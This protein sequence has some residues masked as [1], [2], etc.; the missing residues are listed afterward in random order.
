MHVRGLLAFVT[1]LCASAAIVVGCNLETDT[2]YGNPSGLSH[3]NLPSP[4]V[5]EGG[6]GSD[7]GALCNGAGPIDGGTCQVKFS[8]DIW[9]MMSATGKWGCADGACHGGTALNPFINDPS[10]AYANLTA[11]KIGG[12]PYVNPCTLDV[13]ASSF[14]CNL[15]GSCG[16]QAMPI[17][18]GTR[19][20][21]Q[22]GDIGKVV[23][24][25]QC[26]APFN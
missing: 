7:G 9:P 22:P 10:S 3:T 6:S 15:Q 8:T 24:W 13:D 11:Y 18:G 12:K 19:T 20:A 2:K 5:G 14:T 16:T 17:P 23:Q 4:T 1:L 25:Q 26:G 21:A